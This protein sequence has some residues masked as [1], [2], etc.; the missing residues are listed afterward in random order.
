TVIPQL[1]RGVGDLATAYGAGAQ[2]WLKSLDGALGNGVLERMFKNSSD[3]AWIL[4]EAIDPIVKALVTLTDVGM[5]FMPEIATYIKDMAVE[6]NTFIQAAEADGSLRQWIDDGIQGTKDLFS[7]FGSVLGILDKLEDAARA[8]GIATT[9]GSVADGLDRIEDT[10]GGQVF[11]STLATIFA[12]AKGGA[13]G[14]LAALGPIS[15][16]FRVGG[17]ALA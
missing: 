5:E 4:N 17:P 7:I 11:Q 12:G 13:D 10:A 2:T 15:E 1:E 8:G 16:A 14:L 6:F 9:L 3:A